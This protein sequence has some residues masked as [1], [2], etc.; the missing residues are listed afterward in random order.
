MLRVSDASTGIG[1]LIEVTFKPDNTTIN[2]VR[3]LAS[4]PRQPAVPRSSNPILAPVA[5]ST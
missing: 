2:S 1:Q 3:Q 5:R 4:A